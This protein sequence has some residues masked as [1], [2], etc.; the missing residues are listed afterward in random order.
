MSREE[1]IKD[2]SY[3]QASAAVGAVPK[4]IAH[5]LAIS[6]QMPI[7]PQNSQKIS[8]SNNLQYMVLAMQ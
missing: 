6:L 5:A 8:T 3:K 4:S 2:I 1:K 7:N